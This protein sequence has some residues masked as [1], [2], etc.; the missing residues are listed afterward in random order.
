MGIQKVIFEA[1]ITSVYEDVIGTLIS[2]GG[3]VNW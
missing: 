3:T 2:T 1:E